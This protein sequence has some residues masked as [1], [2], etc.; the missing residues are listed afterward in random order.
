MLKCFLQL[1]RILIN[2]VIFKQK[3]EKY[4]NKL[5]ESFFEVIDRPVNLENH[6]LN[7]QKNIQTQLCLIESFSKDFRH[8]YGRFYEILK[9]FFRK[10]IFR[11][12]IFTPF[13]IG[14]VIK[15]IC[16]PQERSSVS[17]TPGYLADLEGLTLIPQTGWEP[18]TAS[19][20]AEPK[21][22][23]V[24]FFWLKASPLDEDQ[25]SITPRLLCR[26]YKD[27]GMAFTSEANSIVESFAKRWH[28]QHPVNT[29]R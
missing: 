5:E 13:L 3:L 19:D 6:I 22:N 2:S 21:H 17:H 23:R 1:R 10:P 26:V 7:L 24:V 18:Q 14:K 20:D 27:S 11:F 8:I 4:S 28:L 16:L 12:F 15:K 25:S 9:N 29:A